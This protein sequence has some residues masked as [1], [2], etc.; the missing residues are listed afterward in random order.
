M[1]TVRVINDPEGQSLTIWFGDPKR[2]AATGEDEYG[3][4]VMRDEAGK[5][6]G[7]EILGYTGKPSTVELVH[8][9]KEEGVDR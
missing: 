6:L 1:D 8:P 2:E 5:V 9:Y 3:V 7:V 4:I